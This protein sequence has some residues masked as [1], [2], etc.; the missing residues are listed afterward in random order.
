MLYAITG[1]SRGLGYELTQ[2]LLAAGHEVIG[3]G[4]HFPSSLK[5]N[6]RFKFIEQDLSRE[7]GPLPFSRI[8]D[9]FILNAAAIE[10]DFQ[11]GQLDPERSFRIWDVNVKGNLQILYQL[12]PEYIKRDSGSFC[13]IC[14]QSAIRAIGVGGI[15]YAS[16]KAALSTA[17]E[18]LRLTP[19]ASNLHF[20]SIYPATITDYSKVAKRVIRAIDSR[21]ESVYLPRWKHWILVMSRLIPDRL[22]LS[23]IRLTGLPRSVE[24]IAIYL[25]LAGIG[26]A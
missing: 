17:F 24:M 15:A 22:L 5:E 26:L 20:V 3:I 6:D 8:P 1:V 10:N 2:Q 7:F 9:R 4:R 13:L 21:E 11:S 18:C 12:L 19:E 16:S 23:V 14:S 25:I